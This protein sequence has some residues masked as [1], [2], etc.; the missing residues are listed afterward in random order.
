MSNP[1]YYVEYSKYKT[2][3][4]IYPSPVSYNGYKAGTVR[5]INYNQCA[6]REHMSQVEV[7]VD[8]RKSNGI[9]KGSTGE[10]LQCWETVKM[11]LP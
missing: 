4:L 7:E 5:K 3:V 6:N 11:N 1:L 8:K 2:I 10:L 9:P